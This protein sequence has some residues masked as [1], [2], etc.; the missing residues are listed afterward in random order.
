MTR[1]QV[2]YNLQAE[3]YKKLGRADEFMSSE[4]NTKLLNH[5]WS[6]SIKDLRTALK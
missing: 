5:I 1:V 2:K 4:Y 3:L 6:L